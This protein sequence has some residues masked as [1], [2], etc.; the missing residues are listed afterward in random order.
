[1]TTDP[2][3]E[4]EFYIPRY[5]DKN[6]S[7][8]QPHLTKAWEWLDNE[9]DEEF[10]AGTM[11]PGLYKGFYRDPDTNERVDDESYKFIVAVPGSALNRLRSLLV[12]AC[13]VFQQKCIYLSVAGQV[14]FI[15]NDDHETNGS[16]H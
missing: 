15:R 10:Q 7:D 4:C 1:M 12:R 3:L 11:A 14:E 6:L 13:V 9:L 5:R 2:T 16:I 8:G